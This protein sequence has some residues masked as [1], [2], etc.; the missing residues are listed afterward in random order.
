VIALALGGLACVLWRLSPVLILAFG[1]IVFGALLRAMASPL[2]R[3]SGLSDHARVGIAFVVFVAAITGIGFLI[4]PRV[5]AEAD[6]LRRLLPQQIKNLAAWLNTS[7]VGQTLVN[8][9][10]QTAQDSKTFGGLG[11]AAIGFFGGALDAVLI[12]FLGVYFALDPKFYLESALRLLPM[13]RRDQIRLAL[14]AT[15]EALSKWLLA[16][17]AA[18]AIV[19]ALAGT[20]LAIIGVPLAL[21]LGALAAVLEFIPVVGPIIFGVPAVLVAFS[22]GPRMALYALLAYVLVQQL[23]SNVIVPLLQRWAVKMPPVASLLSV[24]AAGILLGPV[25][26]VFA[27]PLAVVVMVLVKHLYVEDTLERPHRG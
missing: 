20:V 25:G 9:I 17:V 22:K 19:G 11:L 16:Q 6:E 15:G 24:V 23:E 13:R 26:I 14:V 7:S 8:S 18:M 2:R 4:G 27:A 10:R 1:G 3:F 12:L 21:V 5:I